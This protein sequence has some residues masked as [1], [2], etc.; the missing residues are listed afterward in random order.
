M[1][2]EKITATASDLPISYVPYLNDNV[3]A[4]YVSTAVAEN[5]ALCGKE[6]EVST[7]STQYEVIC[8]RCKRAWK[9]FL[10]M[11]DDA[12]VGGEN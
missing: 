4:I 10:E 6:F 3:N 2:E 5:C 11:Y 7:F 8:P 12:P 1:K 9:K